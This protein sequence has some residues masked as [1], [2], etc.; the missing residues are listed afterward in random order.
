M[1]MKKHSKKKKQTKL[2][3]I[4]SMTKWDSFNKYK[5]VQGIQINKL[6]NHTK[7]NEGL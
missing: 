4:F 1:Q 7:K 3:S 2:Y 6:I 5:M